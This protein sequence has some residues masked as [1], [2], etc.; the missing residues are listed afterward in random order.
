MAKGSPRPSTSLTLVVERSKLSFRMDADEKL[1][2]LLLTE[3]KL[4]D[5]QIGKYVELNLKILGFFGAAVAIM[6]WLYSDKGIAYSEPPRPV[7]V[8]V[9]SL[10]ITLIGCGVILQGVSTYGIALGYIQYKHKALN[11]AFVKVA[12][13]T[14][15]YPFNATTE[16][17]RGAA[18][19]PVLL[20]TVGLF[21]LHAIASVVLIAISI[22]NFYPSNRKYLLASAIASAGVV[23]TWY[24]E[25]RLQMAIV[26]VFSCSLPIL[27]GEDRVAAADRLH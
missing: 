8:G 18:R 16:W 9:I 15:Q 11:L 24:V 26:H 25:Y 17:W 7:A 14:R 6:G 4:A 2:E 10:A 13:I 19:V 3:K 22:T 21:G 23:F 1:F 12:G 5:E 27:P 20:A